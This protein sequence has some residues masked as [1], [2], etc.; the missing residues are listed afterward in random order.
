MRIRAA[1]VLVL[2]L[3][4]VHVGASAQEI[5]PAGGATPAGQDYGPDQLLVRFRP[6]VAAQRADWLLAERGVSRLRGI[7][8]LDVHV[9]QLP[10]GLSANATMC[11]ARAA[12][13][14]QAD[15]LFGS[16]SQQSQSTKDAWEA[17]GVTAALCG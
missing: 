7:E 10:P 4:L 6:G 15:S 13:V 16:G 2:V 3:V 12:T 5:G 1:I 14:A 8:A 11:N 9:L 17:V